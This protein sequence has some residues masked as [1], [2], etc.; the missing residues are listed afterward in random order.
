MKGNEGSTQIHSVALIHHYIYVLS[1]I[2]E[3]SVSFSDTLDLLISL[4][5][6]LNDVEIKSACN[7]KICDML[8]QSY[9]YHLD[10]ENNNIC[11]KL[12][13]IAYDISQE[14][15]SN[16]YYKFVRLHFKYFDQNKALIFYNVNKSKINNLKFSNEISE[17]INDGSLKN[18]EY[19]SLLSS[20]SQNSKVLSN[21]I[22]TKELLN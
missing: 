3:Y 13:N 1:E 18:I 19:Y 15:N 6:D 5:K 7:F 4:I 21:F 2:L 22:T 9:K 11:I 10:R 17:L 16:D 8:F 20:F 12:L 14:L